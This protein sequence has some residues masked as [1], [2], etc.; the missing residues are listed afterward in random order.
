MAE[1][2]DKRETSWTLTFGEFD[3]THLALRGVDL[4]EAVKMMR[5][6]DPKLTL[7]IYMD[8]GLLGT[9]HAAIRLVTGGF[10]NDLVTIA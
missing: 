3:E 7:Q 10:G 4:W 9:K 6:R 5:H 2:I 1:H 8:L